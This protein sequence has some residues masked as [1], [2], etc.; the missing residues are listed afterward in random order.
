MTRT[1]RIKEL[2]EGIHQ[3]V[4]EYDQTRSQQERKHISFELST[5]YVEPEYHLLEELLPNLEEL[6]SPLRKLHENEQPMNDALH[7]FMDAFDKAV[8]FVVQ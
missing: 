6:L 2:T 7:R 4:K 3:K 8:S 5:E 1:E